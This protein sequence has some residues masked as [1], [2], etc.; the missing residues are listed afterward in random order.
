MRCI[1]N[2][3][4]LFVTDLA[5]VNRPLHEHKCTYGL[6]DILCFVW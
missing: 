6:A 4:R 5:P 1:L 3:G 2:T